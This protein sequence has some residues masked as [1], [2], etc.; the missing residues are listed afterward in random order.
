VPLNRYKLEEETSLRSGGVFISINKPVRSMLWGRWLLKQTGIIIT[1]YS[2][3]L[4]IDITTAENS[5]NNPLQSKHIGIGYYF[6][7]DH[8]KSKK[9]RRTEKS[10]E[11]S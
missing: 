2:P 4:F 1:K 8:V 3:T 9:K 10:D 11:F 5:L 6:V 7:R